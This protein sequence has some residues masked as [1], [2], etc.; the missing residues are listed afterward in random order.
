MRRVGYAAS[1]WRVPQI[2]LFTAAHG[3]TGA[4]RGWPVKIV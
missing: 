1:G 3:P 4:D 2:P